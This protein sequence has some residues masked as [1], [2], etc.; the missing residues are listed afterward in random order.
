MIKS[1]SK[2]IVE[3][4]DVYVSSD[5]DANPTHLYRIKGFNSLVFDETGLDKLKTLEEYKLELLTEILSHFTN[6]SDRM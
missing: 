4:E 2:Y 1:G 5:I 3:I 6:S